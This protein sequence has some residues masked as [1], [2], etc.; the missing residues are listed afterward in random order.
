M[1]KRSG[2]MFNFWKTFPLSD[3]NTFTMQRGTLSSVM[4]SSIRLSNGFAEVVLFAFNSFVDFATLCISSAFELKQVIGGRNRAV[5]FSKW[6]MTYSV[7][8]ACWQ[9]RLSYNLEQRPQNYYWAL[10]TLYFLRVYIPSIRKFRWYCLNEFNVLSRKKDLI[11]FSVR[12]RGFISV[13]IYRLRNLDLN[14]A[15]KLSNRLLR[16]SNWRRHFP[17][18]QSH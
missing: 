13:S 9:R 10:N 17:Y 15:S 2:K 14:V 1:Y 16:V 3:L 5:R 12:Q 4:Q 8:L 11:S 6:N 7:L 18:T